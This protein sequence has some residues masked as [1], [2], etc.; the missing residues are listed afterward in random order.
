MR[1]NVNDI[2]SEE[3]FKEAERIENDPM[4]I[5]ALIDLLFINEEKQSALPS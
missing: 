2:L 1:K 3:D 5:L 4:K